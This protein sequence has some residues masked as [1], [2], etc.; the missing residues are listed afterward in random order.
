MSK[1]VHGESIRG[2]NNKLYGVWGGMMQRVFNLNDVGYKNY[3]GRGI[4]VCDKWKT[5]ANFFIWARSHG[6]QE[7]LQIDRRDNDGNYCPENCRFITRSDNCANRRT[8][9]DFGLYLRKRKDC[10]DRYQVY[11]SRNGR[12]WYGGSSKDF[13]EALKLRDILFEKLNKLNDYGESNCNI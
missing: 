8:K 3:G 11:L 6:Y 10:K 7:G 9:P 2:G 13:N 4:T 5:P 1:I 12:M